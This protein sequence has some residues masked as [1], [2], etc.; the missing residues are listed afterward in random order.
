MEVVRNASRLCLYLVWLATNGSS[1]YPCYAQAEYGESI[2]DVFR[3]DWAIFNN[4]VAHHFVESSVGWVA[5]HG[6]GLA[7]CDDILDFALGETFVALVND[8]DHCHSCFGLHVD[9][10]ESVAYVA[11]FTVEGDLSAMG[12]SDNSVSA[13][14]VADCESVGL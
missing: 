3:F 7:C 12:S 4:F 14:V 9:V 1:P 2:G 6:L 10:W 11:F 8:L 13:G 5:G